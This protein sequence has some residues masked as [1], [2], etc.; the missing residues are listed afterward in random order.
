MRKLIQI[1]GVAAVLATGS[2]GMVAPAEA[3]VSTGVAVASG[4]LGLGVGAAIASDHQRYDDGYGYYAPPPPPPAPVAYYAPPPPPP[5][6]PS[7][8]Y[9]YVQHCRVFDRWDSYEGHYVRS[10]RCY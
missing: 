8:S 7:Y 2:V 6:P 4:L 10:R 5:P 3:R 1:A 9:D